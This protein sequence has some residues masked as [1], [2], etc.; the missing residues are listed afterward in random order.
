LQQR[1][2]FCRLR[3]A[4]EQLKMSSNTKAL[5]KKDLT[6]AELAKFGTTLWPAKAVEDVDELKELLDCCFFQYGDDDDGDADT[7]E[8]WRNFSAYCRKVGGFA[9][10]NAL[11]AFWGEDEDGKVLLDTPLTYVISTSPDDFRFVNFLLQMGVDV[12]V[13]NS[14]G[15]PPLYLFITSDSM[16]RRIRTFSMLVGCGANDK[17]NY[18][19]KTM[20]EWAHLSK[21]N[22]Q[23]SQ[24]IWDDFK[25][26]HRI[27]DNAFNKKAR[28]GK[29]KSD[30]EAEDESE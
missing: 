19:G 9:W 30:S 26:K 12:N 21:D 6:K 28:G 20:V 3:I 29:R 13:R 8:Q 25:N 7:D 15:E 27:S 14:E 2:L 16:M 1:D 4:E 23:V 24:M 11:H 18:G 5:N 22:D 17:A 10:L